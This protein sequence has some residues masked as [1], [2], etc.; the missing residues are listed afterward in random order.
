MTDLH[1]AEELAK[2]V[3]AWCFGKLPM[4]STD[5]DIFRICLAWVDYL[6][7]VEPIPK[8]MKDDDDKPIKTLAEYLYYESG[9][10]S[11]VGDYG[12]KNPSGYIMTMRHEIPLDTRLSSI[13]VDTYWQVVRGQHTYDNGFAVQ[14]PFEN[15]AIT[16]ELNNVVEW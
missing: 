5:M 10:I 6:N 4:T 7:L 14:I 8:N 11:C 12:Y 15:K 16:G 13:V 2:E 9:V 3:S 1:D